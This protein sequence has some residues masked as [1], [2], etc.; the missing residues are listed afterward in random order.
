MRSIELA[1]VPPSASAHASSRDEA[2]QLVPALRLVISRHRRL[3]RLLDLRAPEIIVRNEGRMLRAALGA[4][5]VIGRGM[6][7]R[8]DVDGRLPGAQAAP[9]RAA[10]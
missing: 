9:R 10:R 7:A 5:T 6:D 2:H 3:Q 4:L 1:D 8:R